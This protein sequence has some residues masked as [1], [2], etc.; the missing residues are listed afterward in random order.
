M[1]FLLAVTLGSMAIAAI[2][3]LVA[4]R[5]AG[6]ERRRSDARVAAL[7]GDIHAI[8]TPVAAPH[9]PRA[10]AD[11]LM[12]RP[13]APVQVSGE[14]FTSAQPTRSSSRLAVAVVVGILL[15]GGAAMLGPV[16]STVGSAVGGAVGGTASSTASKGAGP[17]A[18]PAVP[19]GEGVAPL[20]LV[21]LGHER[22]GERLIVRG[23]VRSAGP[24]A[25]LHRPANDQ[26]TAVVFL[27]DRDGGFLASGRATVDSPGPG[28]GGESIFTVMVPGAAHVERYRVSFRTDDHIV[29]HVDRRTKD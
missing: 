18:R 24:A 19:A 29:P 5:L 21:A 11:D 3:S 26:L 23:V 13:S 22:D 27:F 1:M 20:E 15:V 8:D 7:A 10:V 2:M 9:W 12:L 4:W 25:A 14:L 17:T 16:A 28:S 6:E